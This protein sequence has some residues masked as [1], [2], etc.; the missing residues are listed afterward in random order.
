MI[1]PTVIITTEEALKSV[2][3]SIREGSLALGATKW[4]TIRKLV[5]PSAMH[6]IITG[7]ILSIGRAAGETAPIMFT[8][9]VFSQRALPGSLSEPVMALPFHLFVLTTSV[10]GAEKNAY[11][12]AL[13]LLLLV[14]G[15]YLAAIM[16]RNRYKRVLRW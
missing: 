5:I 13:V 11:G 6:G 3:N 7:T 9:V 4:Q 12:T 1:L 10:P 14:I 2:P 15:L 8:A 16:I